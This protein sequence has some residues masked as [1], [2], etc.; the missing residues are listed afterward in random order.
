MA[1]LR[2]PAG[3][4]AH[5]DQASPK[6]GV[7][8]GLGYRRYISAIGAGVGV[9]RRTGMARTADGRSVACVGN[10]PIR[11]CCAEALRLFAPK[12]SPVIELS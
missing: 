1:T 7:T 8:G 2:T 9:G 10:G 11:A 12:R 3:N 5:L 4:H 6:H